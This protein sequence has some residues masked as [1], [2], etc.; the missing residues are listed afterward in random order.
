MLTDNKTKQ[1]KE[2]SKFHEYIMTDLE[3]QEYIRKQQKLDEMLRKVASEQKAKQEAIEKKDKEE[4]ELR[5]RNAEN[6]LN[7]ARRKLVEQA[8]DLRQVE[9]RFR[10]QLRKEYEQKLEVDK[11]MLEGQKAKEVDLINYAEYVQEFYNK[12]NDLYIRDYE[13]KIK[14]LEK[15]HEKMDKKR[16]EYEHF[17]NEPTPPEDPIL[18]IVMKNEK[19]DPY[20]NKKN[21]VEYHRIGG[22]LKEIK[23]ENEFLNPFNIAVGGLSL[24]VVV[25]LMVRRNKGMH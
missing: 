3:K 15:L 9:V 4:F 14:D 20:M 7:E 25:S 5:R 19:L 22:N 16:A 6:L 12:M 21:D 23:A 17:K 24:M 2:K 13:F 8:E 11:N 18:K 10:R 1:P